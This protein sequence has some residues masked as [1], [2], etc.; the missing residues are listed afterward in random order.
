MT[1]WI[2]SLWLYHALNHALV[3]FRLNDKTYICTFFLFSNFQAADWLLYIS[4]TFDLTLALISQILVSLGHSTP[5]SLPSSIKPISVLI[6]GMI[7]IKW[8]VKSWCTM[9]AWEVTC[10]TTFIEFETLRCL[11]I[12]YAYHIFI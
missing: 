7:E 5:I 12:H 4:V 9:G 2:F 10:P 3:L 8:S 11:C 1:H 6:Q